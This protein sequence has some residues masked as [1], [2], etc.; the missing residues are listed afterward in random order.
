VAFDFKAFTSK[1]WES[2][3]KVNPF[4]P[5]LSYGAAK[6]VFEKAKDDVVKNVIKPISLPLFLIVVILV[7]IL[8][9]WKKI[10]KAL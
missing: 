7:L 6:E 2:I 3:K 9:F 1:L 8:I 4:A 10:E 5:A